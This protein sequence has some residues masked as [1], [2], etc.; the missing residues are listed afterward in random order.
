MRVSLASIDYI[1][2]SSDV[3]TIR[4]SLIIINPKTTFFG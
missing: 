4:Q 2:F 3:G 1:I